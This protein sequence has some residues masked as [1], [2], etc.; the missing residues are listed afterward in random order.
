MGSSNSGAAISR[1]RSTLS[2]NTNPSLAMTAVSSLSGR[3][4][5]F[6]SAMMH[7]AATQA[8][9]HQENNG[10][11]MPVTPEG[12]EMNYSLDEENGKKTAAAFHHSNNAAA[13]AIT[14]E[15]EYNYFDYDANVEAPLSPLGV[16]PKRQLE[17]NVFGSNHHHHLYHHYGFR[18]NNN[19]NGS[20]RIGGSNTA[21]MNNWKSKVN[22]LWSTV[23][24]HTCRCF[25]EQQFD[26]DRDNKW[27]VSS[28]TTAATSTTAA[29]TSAAAAARKM[30]QTPMFSTPL[31]DPG[32]FD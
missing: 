11:I 3:S 13:A 14:A 1:D 22:N 27:K 30:K 17:N 5:M 19:N 28:A 8:P 26:R 2:S 25:G 21:A 10:S 23:S 9:N 29:N 24:K 4:S 6:G 16:S 32:L 31:K 7:S 12:C 15:K 18:N 20:S